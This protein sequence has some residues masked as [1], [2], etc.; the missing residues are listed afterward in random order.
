MNKFLLLAVFFSIKIFSQSTRVEVITKENDTLR[1]YYLN[2][3]Y[4]FENIMVLDLEDKLKVKE[5]NGKKKEFFPNELKSFSFLREGKK[6]VF[7]NLEDKAFGLEMYS[8]KLKLYK[9]IIGGYTPI[10]VYVIV[11]PNGG[12]ISYMKAMGFPRLITKKV[13]LQEISD[14]SAVTEKVEKNELK[15][16]TEKGVIELVQSY[17]SS[18]FN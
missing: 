10:N 11:R 2:A 13:I 6:V 18:C 7:V 16:R 3:N 12:K 15:V 5:A 14:C 4:D 9:L 1:N 17:E 8:N